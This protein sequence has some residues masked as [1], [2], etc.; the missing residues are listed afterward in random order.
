L[1]RISYFIKQNTADF[2]LQPSMVPKAISRKIMAFRLGNRLFSSCKYQFRCIPAKG[3]IRFFLAITIAFAGYKIAGALLAPAEDR[4][5]GGKGFPVP[6]F[7][8]AASFLSRFQPSLTS[9]RDTFTDRGRAA[10]ACYSLDTALQKDIVR[11]LKQYRPK[12]GA[13]VVMEPRSGRILALVSYRH[14]SMPDIG[15]Q[16]FLKNIFPAASIFKTVT[17]AAAVEKAQ[18]SARTTV[19]VAGPGH[20]LYRYQIRKTVSPWNELR[21]EDAFAYSINPVFARIGMYDLGRKTLEQ[22]S[23]QFGF[24]ASIPFD[25]AVD[26]SRVTVPD[27]TSYAMAELASGFNRTTT[28]SPVHGALIAAAVAEDGRMPV[29]HIVDSIC[30]LDDGKCLYR[31]KPMVW[32]TSMGADAA[33]ELR[34]MM[35]RVAEMG[36]CRKTFKVLKRCGWSAAV[37]YGGKTGSLDVDSLGKIDWFIGFAT[38]ENLPD[39]RLAVAVVTVHGRFWTVHSSFIGAEIFRKYF[40]PSFAR[41]PAGLGSGQSV[42]ASGHVTEKPKG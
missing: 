16:L 42:S 40:R 8:T 32:K 10:V 41:R 17:T 33:C 28:L 7:E 4:L 20:T 35:S 34:N 29:P 19:P 6:V 13:A 31:Q 39:L 3:R 24:N 21:F 11:T 14:D 26:P 1:P 37:N 30:R 25:L 22:Y 5:S 27:D 9:P 23:N 18:Y 2:P 36:T 12:Y 15:E 38:R